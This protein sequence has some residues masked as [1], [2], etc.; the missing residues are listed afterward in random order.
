MRA[1]LLHV[2]KI[3]IAVMS[4]LKLC[5][6]NNLKK[7]A[8]KFH[9]KR[10]QLWFI[11]LLVK[12]RYWYPRKLVIKIRMEIIFAY[13]TSLRL[14]LCYACNLKLIWSWVLMYLL[15]VAFMATGVLKWLILSFV[16]VLLLTLLR[17]GFSGVS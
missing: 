7:N 14:I 4:L 13:L 1:T 2:I 3:V 6:K 5:Y 9:L 11:I 8:R 10:I 15:S 17:L 12:S 16:L